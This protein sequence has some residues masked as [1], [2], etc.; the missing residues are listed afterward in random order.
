[1]I[2]LSSI[3][4]DSGNISETIDMLKNKSVSVPSWDKLVKDYEPTMHE[5]LSDTTTLKD[6]IRAD[7][8]L[9]KSS[10]IIIG[11]EKLHV[12]RLSEF[13]FSIPVKRVYHNVDD[14]KL[15]KDIVNAIESVYK[16][17]RID[18]E[19]LKRATALYASC[20]IFTVWYAVKK[21]NRLYG[22]ESKYKLKCKTF[23]P[24]NGVRLY[25][26]LNEMD[27]MLA[28][29]FEYKKTVK[30][31]EVT[32]FETYT[33]DKHYIWKQ[34]DGVGKWDVVLTQQ[35][36]DGDTTNGE[37][38]VL[39]KIPG[40]YGW[41]AKPVYD[42]L[43]P[44][45]AEIEYSLSR[46]S[47]VIAYNSA[48]LLKV[49]GATKGKEDKGESY[50]VVHC[51]QGGDVS[52]VSWSQSVE[53]LK[54]HV[55]SMQKMYWMQAQIPDISFDNMKGLGNIGYDARQTL[56]SDAHLRVGD[57]SGTWI[58]FFERECNVIKAFLAAI[59]SAWAGEMDNIGVEHII[60]PYI[61]NDELAEITKRMKANGNKPIESQLESIQKYGESSDAE[62]TFA[63]IQ[64]ENAIEAVNSASAF[65]LENQ[66]L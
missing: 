19:N 24:M 58:E 47:N 42:G 56:L 43:S 55:D 38:I 40:V 14:N 11:M 29:S 3:D 35:T 25:P 64:K 15:R 18:S 10:R 17:V 22:F 52:Y 2:D 31:K 66:V 37:E 21:R 57:E 4:F 27:D 23:S 33:K 46:N 54:Y 26:L 30:D 59:N 5:I 36:E 60:T 16:N 20:E 65:N 62:K 7:G 8:Q 34:S 51:E 48:P 41:R 6:K 32:F 50:R 13:T 28:M 39:M 49:V 9:D 1:M 53:A 12:R 44:I 63:M 45:R 61:Q